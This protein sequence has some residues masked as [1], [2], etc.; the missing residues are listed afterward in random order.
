MRPH[1]LQTEMRKMGLI[2]F[3][4]VEFRR[5]GSGDKNKYNSQ[6]SNHTYHTTFASN[7]PGGVTWHL[8]I[9]STKWNV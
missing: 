8:M 6:S 2:P 3:E 4:I 7:H 5:K 9:Y 1:T